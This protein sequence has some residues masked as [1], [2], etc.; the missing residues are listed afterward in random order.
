MLSGMRPALALLV[1]L[2]LLTA[3]ASGS[4]P[5]D[6]AAAPAPSS[7]TSASASS[8]SASSSSASSSSPDDALVVELD[9]GEGGEPERYTLSCTDPVAGD[10]PD[11]A[12]ACV[13]LQGLADPFAPL[14]ADLICTEQ[15]G[16]PQTARVSGRWAGADVD[17]R[18]ARTNGCEISQWDRL[19]PLLPGPVG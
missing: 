17:L 13:H 5:D 12:A 19:G 10:L 11:A 18:L 3:C 7:S 15:F 2:L 8:S 1:P 14:A 9:R 6:G 16:G 4:E